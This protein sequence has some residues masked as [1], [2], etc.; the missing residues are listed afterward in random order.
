MFSPLTTIELDWI[1]FKLNSLLIWTDSIRNFFLKN[2][3]NV[4]KFILRN[5]YR[6][7]RINDFDKYFTQCSSFAILHDLY[8]PQSVKNLIRLL[9]ELSSSCIVCHSF[10]F[11]ADIITN[12]EKY[13]IAIEWLSTRNEKNKTD[14]SKCTNR[15]LV[16]NHDAMLTFLFLR[17]QSNCRM[18]IFLN[19]NQTNKSIILTAYFAEFLS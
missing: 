1:A 18:F 7:N 15:F 11:G 10:R 3:F 5:I 16:L 4:L 9:H 13:G 2:N 6:L 8:L 12:I 19:D 17:R 14:S